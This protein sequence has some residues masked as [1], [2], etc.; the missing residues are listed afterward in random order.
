MNGW[1]AAF[2]HPYFAV[3][4]EEGRFELTNVPPGTYT[5]VAWHEGYDIVSFVSSRPHESHERAFQIAIGSAGA[6]SC[7]A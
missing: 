1:M 7:V 3:T 6:E 5:L 4:D 2:S